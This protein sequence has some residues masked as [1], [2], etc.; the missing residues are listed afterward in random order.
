MGFDPLF[1]FLHDDDAAA[2]ICAALAKNLRGVYNVAGPPP[3]P[4]SLLCRL[5]GNK[6]IPLP[7]PVFGW[8]LGRFG[9]PRLPSGAVMHV[10]Y[11]VV[12]D[13]S[14]FREATGWT[15]RYGEDEAAAS[16]RAARDE[17]RAK[18]KG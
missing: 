17:S 10:K 4:L 3:V 18:A 14:A 16:Y 2:A 8:L 6:S 12:V 11:P 5:T 1:Q 7:E 9:L 13:S 15:H